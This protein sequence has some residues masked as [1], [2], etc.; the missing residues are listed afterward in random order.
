MNKLTR[1]IILSISVILLA[2]T[3]WHEAH[4]LNVRRQPIPHRPIFGAQQLQPTMQGDQ[5]Q[6][7]TLGGRQ[8]Q[9]AW[10][11]AANALQD[12]ESSRNITLTIRP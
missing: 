12:P 2:F 6:P 8:I 4:A 7:E 5:L 1:I 11:G 9:P 10:T 3:G